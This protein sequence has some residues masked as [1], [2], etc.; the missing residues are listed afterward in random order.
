MGDGF[1]DRIEHELRTLSAEPGVRLPGERRLEHRRTAAADGVVVPDDLM[2]VL[3]DVRRARF[4]GDPGLAAYAGSERS[5][6]SAVPHA[7]Q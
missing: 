4:A 6:P 3:D 7:T 1:V 2:A 5:A